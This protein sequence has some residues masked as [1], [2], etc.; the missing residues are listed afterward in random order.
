MKKFIIFDLDGTLLDTSE[1][2]RKVLNETLAMYGFPPLPVDKV[3][4]IVGGG[5]LNL[6]KKAFG[7][8]FNSIENAHKIFCEKYAENENGLTALYE[9]EA[10]TL[11][12]LKRRGIGLCIQTNK[13]NAATQR[14]YAD[15]LSNY[16]FCEVLGQTEYY[17]VKPDPTLTLEILRRHNVNKQQCLFVGDGET[18]V[19]CAAAAGVDCVAALWGYRTRDQLQKA[20]AVN[21]AFKFADILK[22]V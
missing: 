10:E 22:F 4:R 13:P 8:H 5:S 12:I 18:D 2:I 6:I 7:E 16:G 14:V 15:L 21:F 17:P 1:D 9:G 11:E 19:Q 3:K 20:G